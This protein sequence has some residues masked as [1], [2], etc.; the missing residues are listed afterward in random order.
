MTPIYRQVEVFFSIICCATLYALVIGAGNPI[1]LGAVGALAAFFGLNILVYFVG[2]AV[3]VLIF[4]SMVGLFGF[5]DM[6]LPF[7]MGLLVSCAVMCAL[8]ALI[9]GVMNAY[10]ERKIWP[11]WRR[12]TTNLPMPR[13]WVWAATTAEFKKHVHWRQLSYKIL[14]TLIPAICVASMIWIVVG[15]T[16]PHD[17]LVALALVASCAGVAYFH[18][19]FSRADLR[20]IYG[21]MQPIFILSAVFSHIMFGPF[22]AAFVVCL[23]V[24]GSVM[25]LR[26]EA[27]FIF[28]D[29]QKQRDLVP[30]EIGSDR[31]L[32]SAGVSENLCHIKAIIDTHSVPSD[33]MFA[34]PESPGMLALFGFKTAVYDTF[35]VYMST[36]ESR[37]VMLAE[38]TATA[39]KVAIVTDVMIDG[40]KD[41]LFS[42]NYPDVT[43]YFYTYYDIALSDVS[44]TVFVRR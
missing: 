27:D 17:T 22:G 6:A 24:I 20:H 9:P 1:G 31:F 19:A 16:A 3:L 23:L 13:P 28:G 39:P 8:I 34:A 36:P 11:L 21:V 41:L 2:S 25:L 38:V 35:P 4:G 12:G 32:L 44:Q 33:L 43:K 18:H 7:G 37:Q 5:V 14:F 42:N 29:A 30:F 40:R 26:N 15:K 10:F